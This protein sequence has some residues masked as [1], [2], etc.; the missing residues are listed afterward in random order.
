LT[1]PS[2]S[3]SDPRTRVIAV[4]LISFSIA[5]RLIAVFRRDGLVGEELMLTLNVAGRSYAGLLQPLSYAQM[6]PI[7]FLWAERLT[8]QVNGVDQAA[9]RVLPFV[10]GC[11]MLILLWAVARRTLR[12]GE[13]LLALGL[14]AT[15][16]FLI[17]SS[18]EVTPYALDALMSMLVVASALSV[19][20]DITNRIAWVGLAGLGT[21]ALIASM[22]AFFVLIAVIAALAWRLRAGTLPVVAL[23]LAA[24]AMLWVDVFVIL[25]QVS[26]KQIA[27]DPYML[28]YWGA[29]MLTPGPRFMTWWAA[30]V[31]ESLWPVSYWMVWVRLAP[32][33]GIACVVGAVSIGRRHGM[34]AA[35]LLLGP[36]AALLGASAV[37]RYPLAMRLSAFATPLLILAAAAGIGE[38]ARWLNRRIPS[39]RAEW[40]QFLV[41]IPSIMV[42]IAW[43]LEAPGTAQG[44]AAIVQQIEQRR[45]PGESVYIFHRAIGPWAF[46]STDWSRPDR[47]RLAWIARIASPQG[48]SFVNSPP[49]GTRRVGEGDTLV[50]R[51]RRREELF[52]TASGVQGRAWLPPEPDQRPDWQARADPGWAV[53]E[54]ARLRD[55]GRRVW[56]VFTGDS[57]GQEVLDLLQ[58]IERLGGR[59][60]SRS[61]V[62]GTTLYSIRF[63]PDSSAA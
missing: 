11:L 10:A 44:M 48:P 63:G 49:R 51:Y 31:E 14:A 1:S 7:P 53:A 38:G 25:H 36:L 56:A 9:L 2:D 62:V 54:A 17:D 52:G 40:I 18:A 47:V 57:P 19:L 45:Q 5:L 35:L 42:G 58:A 21:V 13:A 33:L 59:I 26:Y 20:R 43:A 37:G 15:S 32:V 55:R 60:E 34:S 4:L 28:K 41:V 61:E 27:A 3:A 23:R 22:P 8:I 24:T 12:E 50:Y 39:I 30:G 46:Y 16:P 6:A 29:A